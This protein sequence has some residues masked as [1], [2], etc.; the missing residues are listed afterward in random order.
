ML[1]L[2][3]LCNIDSAYAVKRETTVK[4]QVLRVQ[5]LTAVFV[6]FLRF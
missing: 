3:V 4:R 5:S 6:L 1:L 2:C